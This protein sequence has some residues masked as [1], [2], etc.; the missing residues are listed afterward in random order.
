MD[1]SDDLF[2]D[3]VKKYSQI[4]IIAEREGNNAKRTIAKLLLNSLY[5]RFGLKYEPYTIDF[6]KSD[7]ADEISINHEVLDRVYIA[8]NIECIKYIKAPSDIL[9]ELNRDEYNKLKNKTNLDGENVVR[10][11]TISALITSYASIFMNPFL[12][13][14][15]NPC[16]YTDTDSLFLK[17]KLDD[18]Y[19]GN[20][21][22]QFSFKGIASRAYF[23]SPKTYCLIMEDGT[24]IIKCKGL[25]N[26]LLN[27]NHFKE[28]LAGNSVSF[29]SQKIFTNLKRG[30]GGIKSM[31]FT[32]NPEI[33]NRKTIYRDKI[34]FDTEPHHVIDGIIQ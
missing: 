16:Y 23:I 3:F 1:K 27:E 19:V 6:V 15:D 31:M 32:I 28:F 18:K 33:N 34:N 2:K 17:Y 10:N 25:D 12:N 22:G 30:T 5:G 11:I 29:D 20:G 26:K 13:L 7:L 21:L 8:N 9:K 14:S 4:K 24:V